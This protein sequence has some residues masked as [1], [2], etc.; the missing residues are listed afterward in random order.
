MPKGGYLPKIASFEDL[1]I[2]DIAKLIDIIYNITLKLQDPNLDKNQVKE[3]KAQLK[4]I[5]GLLKAQNKTAYKD[6]ADQ[7]QYLANVKKQYQENLKSIDQEIKTL[8]AKIKTLRLDKKKA[9]QSMW[10]KILDYQSETTPHYQ[11]IFEGE[12]SGPTREAQ[13]SSPSGPPGGASG[14]PRG[15]WG[16]RSLP[17]DPL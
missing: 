6:V 11:D 15:I 9:Q 8:S 5:K 1:K 4:V 2:N 14:A 13:R 17:H 7:E 12:T 10:Q 16:R 3:L